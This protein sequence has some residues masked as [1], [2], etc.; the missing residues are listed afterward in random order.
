MAKASPPEPLA[1]TELVT[2]VLDI[3]MEEAIR[4]S[5]SDAP[6][7]G[8][9]WRLQRNDMAPP[10]RGIFC[11]CSFLRYF[12]SFKPQVLILLELRARFPQVFIMRQLPPS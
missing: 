3:D 2:A 8:A 7:K 1:S 12:K 5:Y 6:T 4:C 10:P 9:V 11:M